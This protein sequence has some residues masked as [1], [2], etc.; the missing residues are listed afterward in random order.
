[1]DNNLLLLA[2]IGVVI[3]ASVSTTQA[4][5][6]TRT[7]HVTRQQTYDVIQNVTSQVMCSK[8]ESAKWTEGVCRCYMGHMFYVVNDKPGCFESQQIDSS[9]FI[10]YFSLS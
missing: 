4:A 2:T 7:Y 6:V 1:M 9:M 5:N 8:Y 3:M 10:K